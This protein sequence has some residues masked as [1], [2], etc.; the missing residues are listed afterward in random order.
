MRW[1]SRWEAGRTAM[2]PGGPTWWWDSRHFQ[3]TSGRLRLA[4]LARAAKCA[5]AGVD[6]QRTLAIWIPAAGPK[7]SALAGALACRGAAVGTGWPL[8]DLD[9]QA[10]AAILLDQLCDPGR[11][12]F[13]E[14]VEVELPRLDHVQGLFPDRR[15]PWIRNGGGHGI[16]QGICRIRCADRPALLQQ[17][18]APEQASDDVGAGGFSANAHGVLELL[19]QPRIGDQ[20]GHA[21]HRFDQLALRVGLGWQCFH[22]LEFGPLDPALHAVR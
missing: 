18:S 1:L 19:L 12:F 10:G 2:S 14:R 9:C 5:L 8:R 3:G 16:D 21:L 20:L 6:G 22:G 11:L 13:D 15:C 17:I 4:A 7:W